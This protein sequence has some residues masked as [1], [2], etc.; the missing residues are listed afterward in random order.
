MVL[1]D[2]LTE[3]V[4]RQAMNIAASAMRLAEAA[5]RQFPDIILHRQGDEL[6]VSG[7]GLM[8]RWL[9]D[10]RLRFALWRSR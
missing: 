3:R 4:E 10:V 1:F 5:Y 2:R 8:R 7:R 6:V 9:G